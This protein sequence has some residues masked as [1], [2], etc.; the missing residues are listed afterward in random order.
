MSEIILRNVSSV[1]SLEKN[2]V[3]MIDN[4]KLNLPAIEKSSDNFYKSSSQMKNVTLDITELT[5]MAAIKHIL[6]VIE[7]VKRALEE[8][9]VKMRKSQ[10]EIE[11]IKLDLLNETKDIEMQ[12]KEL[13]IYELTANNATSEKYVKGAI[14]KLNFFTNQYNHIMKN[15]GKAEFTEE[16]YEQAEV[17]HHIMTAMKQALN[18]ARARGGTIDEGNH[19]YL[20]EMGINGAVAQHEINGLLLLEQELID[21]GQSPSHLLVIKWLENFADK[22][23]KDIHKFIEYRGLNP[24]D[25]QSL[26][27]GESYEP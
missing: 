19:I 4:I 14:R 27:Q 3:N 13:R 16:D 23:E 26:A 10:I 5:P 24:L 21:K 22:Y 9:F 25:K 20:F 7:E 12:K 2:Y 6:A 15:I 11:E 17:R 1:I 8:T 18:A